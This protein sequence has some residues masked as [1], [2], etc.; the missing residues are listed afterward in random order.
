MGG[1][2]RR[3]GW[4]Q[5]DSDWAQR[6]VADSHVGPGDVVLDIGAGLGVLTAHLVAAGARV[7]AVEAHAGRAARLRAT[8][9]RDVIVVETDAT[10]LRLPRRPFHVVANPPFAVTTALL[11]RLVQRGSRLESA[12]LVVQAQAARRWVSADAPGAARWQRQFD[13]VLGRRLPR[14]AFR[15]PPLVDSRVLVLRRRP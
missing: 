3:W 6:L 11:R 10:D 8:F 4:H 14:A 15:P 13:A 2:R 1:S 7:I 9:G 5:L 12:H